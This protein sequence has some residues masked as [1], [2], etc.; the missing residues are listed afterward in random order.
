MKL[1]ISLVRTRVAR[2]LLGLFL[3]CAV[4][5]IV[6]FAALSYREVRDGI[7]E[8]SRDQ[9]RRESRMSVMVVIE[10][11]NARASRLME[12]AG[13]AAPID[14]D[15]AMFDAV[16]WE[17]PDGTLEGLK[18]RIADV[19]ALN[20]RQRNHLARGLPVLL[21]RASAAD[22]NLYFTLAP[23][24]SSARLWGQVSLERFATELD[25]AAG[26][27]E[28]CILTLTGAA[29]T[30]PNGATARIAASLTN[31]PTATRDWDRAGERLMTAHANA[32]LIPAFAAMP[33]TVSLTMPFGDALEPLAPFRRTFI[34]GVMLAAILVFT[35]SHIEIRRHMAPL[36]ILTDGTQR[37]HTGDFS[38]RVDVK[39]D[40]EFKDLAGSFNQMASELERQ[41]GT[42]AA[43]HAVDRA[44]LEGRS[45][46]AMADA[47]LNRTCTLLDADHVG[48]AVVTFDAE[49]RW[50][51]HGTSADANGPVTEEVHPT[52]DDLSAMAGN[53]THLRIAA[54]RARPSYCG[55]V[56]E[57]DTELVVYPILRAGVPFAALVVSPR[58]GGDA[59]QDS[60]EL[61]RQLADQ[62]ALGLSNAHMLEELH[63]LSVGSLTALART[64]DAASPWTG[65]HSERVTQCAV[66]IGRRMGLDDADLVR[67]RHGGLL[68]DIGKIGIPATILD[69]PGRLT[70][71]E[72]AVMQSHPVIGAGIVQSVRA[73]R[74]LVPLVM[75]HHELLD[76]SGYP[77]G[78]HGD[79]I[80]RIVQ[81]LTVADVYDA[82]VSDRPY[83]AGL[84][85]AAAMATLFDGIG[86]KFAPLAVT[87]LK[88][89]IDDQWH[90]IELAAV[91]TSG[92]P[93][94]APIDTPWEESFV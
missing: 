6:T 5:P 72:L 68:H 93:P 45:A 41:F 87:T 70:A 8:K 16:A 34:L 75:H 10:Q 56:H 52:P 30:C 50:F 55:R 63:A 71:E 32:F 59:P 83:R 35:I 23:T 9:L 82:L 88:G 29:V 91:P 79:Q 57:V 3:V 66:E 78:L 65:G 24:T 43:F 39:S 51:Y 27:H 22:S 20:D 58:M 92:R 64:I 37:L 19:P 76:G 85:A 4:A 89:M 77:H 28:L 54:G 7:V 26:G 69:K 49:D 61:G 38:T 1:E 12:L 81:I 67:L 11:L 2:R 80:P 44:A 73:F 13:G 60:V 14:G 17:H 86:R 36:A 46:F 18:G 47:V 94:V 33:W 48:L 21:V 62:F 74:D 15:G 31:Q 40:D 90:P 53:H 42:L 84:S 25:V